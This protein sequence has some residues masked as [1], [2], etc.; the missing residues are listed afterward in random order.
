MKKLIVSIL[1]LCLVFSASVALAIPVEVGDTVTFLPGV[2][3]TGGGPF[4]IYNNNQ[5]VTFQSFC[6][7]RNE[8]IS[9]GGTYTVAGISGAAINGGVGGAIDGEDPLSAQT[10]WLF[11][12]FT[13]GT[14][15]GYDGSLAK[16]GLLQNAIWMLENELSLSNA[17][18]VLSNPFYVLA[19]ASDWTDIGPVRVLNLVTTKGPAQDQLIVTPEPLSLL[20]LGFGLM[21]VAAVRRKV[22]YEQIHKSILKGRARRVLPFVWR[23]GIAPTERQRGRKP[24]VIC[25]LDRAAFLR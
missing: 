10:A 11:Y 17:G 16:Q 22:R 18:Y 2:G 13:I 14:L 15:Q 25:L 23:S 5:G 24:L 21:G 12:N 7:E 4:N 1:S 8:Y 6:L 19:M 3:P 20:L 9:I